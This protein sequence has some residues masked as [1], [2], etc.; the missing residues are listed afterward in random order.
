MANKPLKSI[1]FP[2][3]PDTYTIPQVDPTL[4]QSGQ[5]ADAKAVGDALDNIKP[6]DSVPT[7]GSANVVQSGGVY[8]AL[9]GKVDAVSG[10]GLSTNDYTDAE[11]Q[12]VTD[13]TTDLSAITTATA[14]DVG[15]A[16]KAKTVSNGKVTEW[17]F[18]DVGGTN[19]SCIVDASGDATLSLG[20][21]DLSD[22]AVLV[23]GTA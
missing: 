20:E 8:S 13:A 6:V 14:E 11:K 19:I 17:E 2:E 3:L 12:K 1:K 7:Q 18:G 16:L 4:T 9:A 5:A 10:K 22:I 15:K 21:E 23:G